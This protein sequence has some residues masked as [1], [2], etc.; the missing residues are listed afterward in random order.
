MTEAPAHTSLEQLVFHAGRL[1]SLQTTL[2]ESAHALTHS[3]PP[4]SVYH[5]PVL[6]NTLARI[7]SAPSYP[8]S[9]TALTGPLHARQS[10]LVFPTERLH[11]SAQRAVVGMSGSVLGGFGVAWAGW[12]TELQLLGGI[13][14]VGMS[15]ETALGVG[16][17]GAAVGVRW[18]VGRWEKAKRRW[19]K[20]WGRIGEGL[21]R[22]LKVG[23]FLLIEGLRSDSSTFLGRSLADDVGACG[24]CAPDCVHELRGDC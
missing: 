16:M 15:T 14:D 9:P 4:S 17:L 7:A 13:I 3:F 6:H 11:A 23:G 2:A 20:D 19:W 12:A 24:C 22:D 8:L 21:D 18:A 5:S 1:A 10:Q